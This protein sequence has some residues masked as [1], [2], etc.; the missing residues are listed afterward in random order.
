MWLASLYILQALLYILQ[1]CIN[2]VIQILAH[3]WIWRQKVRKFDSRHLTTKRVNQHILGSKFIEA[4][5]FTNW[6]WRFLHFTHFCRGAGN[7]KIYALW[8]PKNCESWDPSQKTKVPALIE[9]PAFACYNYR[10]FLMAPAKLQQVP[11]RFSLF[12]V[13][14]YNS[15]KIFGENMKWP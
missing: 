3:W 10:S 2:Y 1:P 4:K 14:L 9:A 8:E 15:D 5:L 13:H 7:V 11:Y 6:G 12:L